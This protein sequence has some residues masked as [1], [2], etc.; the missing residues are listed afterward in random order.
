[1]SQLGEYG[2]S[3]RNNTAS[4]IEEITRNSDG[5]PRDLTDRLAA[6]I[7]VAQSNLAIAE[8]ADVMRS[9]A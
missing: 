9:R 4:M 3:A 8:L 1:M 5:T 6:G 7:L 2:R